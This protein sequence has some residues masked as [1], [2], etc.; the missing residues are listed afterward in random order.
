MLLLLPFPLCLSSILLQQALVRS[1][2]Q[3]GNDTSQCLHACC[4][5]RDRAHAAA[6]AATVTTCCIIAIT[7]QQ[8]WPPTHPKHEGLGGKTPLPS[9]PFRQPGLHQVSQPN[10][11]PPAESGTF[12]GLAV[13]LLACLSACLF[14]FICLSVCLCLSVF[15][16]LS[17]FVRPSVCLSVCLSVCPSVRPS[18]HLSICLSVVHPSVCPVFD[19]LDLVKSGAAYQGVEYG[20]AMLSMKSS[21]SAMRVEQLRSTLQVEKSH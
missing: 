10:R 19:L 9:R 14:V 21:Q 18:V 16:C 2:N 15:I 17:V 3:H 6:G 5:C 11:P 4:H 12:F 7:A 20:V 13:F 8:P 1:F